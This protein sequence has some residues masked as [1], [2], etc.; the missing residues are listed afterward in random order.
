VRDVL[1]PGLENSPPGW[2]R[3][4]KEF[5]DIIKI[6]RTHT[7]DATPLTLGQE[8]SGYAHAGPQRD[9]A[10]RAGAPGIYELAQGGTAV[11][12][13]L[14]T[15]PGWG[16]TV[17]ANMARITGL[18]FVT[19]P[20][21][22]EALAAHD[23]MVFMSGALATRHG[24]LQDRQRHPLPRLRPALGPR[25]ADPA[26]ERAGS[27]IM[28]GKVNPTQ[29]E[30]MTQVCAHIHRQR[31]GD[32][33]RRVQG[34]FELNVYNPMMAYNLLQSMTLLGDAADSFTE[35]MLMGIEA[36]EERIE[37]LM[38]ES[39]MLVTALAPTIGY[40][41]ATKV[42]KTAHKN[43]TTLRE[44]AVE[45]TVERLKGEYGGEIYAIPSD[46]GQ[47]VGI[48]HLASEIAKCEEKV[49]VLIN[50]A[51]VAWGASLDEFPEHGWDK[52]M[53]VNV[54][55]VFFLTQKLMPLLRKSA[56]ADS[57]ARVINIAS[58]DGM[59]TSPMSGYCYGT[60]KAAVIHLTRFMGS[61]LAGENIL[62]N[63]IAPGPFPTYMLSTGV[64]YKGE[65]EKTLQASP[66]SCRPR[67]RPIS[68]VIRS[69]ATA[70]SSQ[71]ADPSRAQKVS[72]FGRVRVAPQHERGH[73]GA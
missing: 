60:S 7:Q 20:N 34:H 52:V 49:D 36:N 28:P 64:G 16:E 1:L 48:E 18:P 3:K 8:F 58:I 44:E 66:C 39:L 26:G 21:K 30:A 62:V 32:R 59:H 55:G 33:L 4:G 42:A 2:R 23:A 69:R 15:S 10:D 5:K 71:P 9:R 50:N 35:R 57:P 45:E 38:R 41:N 53:D 65:T 25:R 70:E 67:L 72:H 43:G 68:T 27:S 31:R 14:N 56:S 46:V 22:F 51:G 12:T 17:A 13:G 61:Q 40:D 11:G 19:A 6:G 54:K 29:A 47:M 24:L 63:G 73:R 37:K